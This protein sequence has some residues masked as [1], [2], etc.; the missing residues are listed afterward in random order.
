MPPKVSDIIDILDILA[1]PMLAE[2]WDNIGLQLGDPNWPVQNIW[3]ALDPLPQVVDAACQQNV[4]LLITHHPLIFNPLNSIDFNTP[5]GSIVEMATRHRL[6]IFA[7]HTNLDS[8]IGGINDILAHRLGLKKLEPLK[9]GESSEQYKM[10]IMA[11][12]FAEDSI[13]RVLLQI[14]PGNEQQ[15]LGRSF[16]RIMA[17]EISLSP[18][19]AANAQNAG[20][21]L[22]HDQIRFEIAVRDNEHTNIIDALKEFLPNESIWYDV[23]PLISRR[24]KGGIGR[25]GELDQATDLK[26]FALMIKEKL[27]IKIVKMVGDPALAL[28]KVAVCSGSGASLLKDF[29]ASGAQVYVSGDLRYHDARDVQAANLGLIDIGH[30]SSEHIIVEFLAKRLNEIL[31]ESKLSAVVDVCDIEMDPFAFL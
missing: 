29:F 1:P 24:Q 10:V 4:D 8:A 21:V 26:S 3:I 17:R 19:G 9:R 18:N 11:P 30:F 23:Y 6:A 16:H 27:G 28:K 2:D 20:S 31:S 15:D 5:L 7:A 12:K 13:I 22:H 25:I 14:L